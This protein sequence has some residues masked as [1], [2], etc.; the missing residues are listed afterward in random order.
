MP[1]IQGEASIAAGATNDN[2]LQGSQFEYLPFNASLDFG[3][4]GSATGLIADVYTGQ[5]TIAENY[6]LNITNRYPIFPDDYPLTDVAGGGER[7]KVRVRNPTAG[8]LT[9]FYSV[10]ISPI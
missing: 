3:L 8:A 5:D 7:M 6:A 9:V 2:L 4:N 10:R 1:V